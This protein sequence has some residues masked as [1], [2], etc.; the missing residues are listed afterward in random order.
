MVSVED[1]GQGSESIRILGIKWLPTGAA[2][3]SVTSDGKLQKRDSK[4]DRTVPGQGEIQDSQDSNDDQNGL[5]K[6]TSN[7]NDPTKQRL[8]DEESNQ[9]ISEGMEAEEGEFVNMEIA[10]AYKARANGKSLRNLAKN[11]HLYLG[12]Y[13]PG[14]IKFPVWV[15]LQG[16]VG[17]MRLRL[18]LTP[19]PP[20]FS[21]CTL[22]FLGQP[23]VD[24]SCVPLVKKGL[25]IMD[26]P[27]ISN[28]VQSA[29]DAAMA[30]YVAPKSLT[31]DL[32]EMLVGDDFKKD[33]A[34]RGILVVRIRKAFDFKEGDT[35][36]GPIKSGSADAYVTAGWAKFGKPMWS[37]R[38]IESDMNPAWD[39]TGYILVT[40]EELNVRERLRVQ[41]W[42]S[43]R[44]TADDDLGRIEVDLKE[45]M[46]DDRS[47]G[48]MW[49]RQDGFRSLKAGEGMPGKLD[50]SV[51]YF[52][53]TRILEEQ[54]NAASLKDD[55]SLK[56]II[57][58]D[59]KSIADLKR[60]VNAES[61]RKLREMKKDA[62]SELEQ[63]KEQDLKEHEDAIIIATPP[64]KD[65]PSGILSI[66]IH[67]I[68]GLELEKI[69]K[70]QQSKD[71]NASDEEEDGDD[72]PSAYCTIILNHQKVFRTR[73]KPKNAKP[74]FN[75]GCER[76]IRDANSSEIM[77]S[78]RDARVHE[79]DAL[80]GIIVLP[81]KDL[82]R[83]RSQVIDIYPLSGGIGYGKCRI[84]MVFRSVQLQLPR[85]LRG[86][87]Y[88]TVDM[89]QEIKIL[90][91][92]EAV[93]GLRLKVETSL[94]KGKYQAGDDAV[95]KTKR[96]KPVRLAVKKRYSS[97]LV[98]EF[99][100]NSML[101]DSTPAFAVF[102]LRDIPDDEEKTV[103]LAIW[104][105]DLKRA[106]TNVLEEYGEKLGDMEVTLKFWPG[107][108]GYHTSLADKDQNIG[109]V[110]EVLDC[111]ED[112]NDIIDGDADKDFD[113]Q[114]SSSSSSDE[115]DDDEDGLDRR[116]HLFKDKQQSDL[117]NDGKRGAVETL[118]EY[119]NHRKQLHRR[120]RGLMQWKGPRTLQWM[121]NKM[122]RG[123]KKVGSLFNHHERDTEIETE[124]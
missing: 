87:D 88:G 21:L 85:E 119:K 80:L 56:S 19:D 54:V 17:V 124:V 91:G 122:D 58:H 59:T 109:D 20:F 76:F 66:V 4:S 29:V 107:L 1:I 60:K 43:D 64:P 35:G 41:L 26:V 52:S 61:E 55:P 12:F 46:R 45:L 24:M 53:K 67:Q 86:W 16:V 23:K 101:K 69:N 89:K 112:N 47:N 28:F 38:V 37:T 15:E 2:S 110:M 10:F 93:K 84:S 90:S 82:F 39:E 14:N 18:Q 71:E 3:K 102:W 113:E 115:D 100:S 83:R 48:K 108:S 75:A 13:L 50:W 120:N 96:G 6:S 81:L 27:V 62:T 49:D 79:D 95:W 92:Q 9:N 40:P 72:L 103:K 22:T 31:L 117:S 114:S 104:S 32:K 105:G 11:A 121:A 98:F 97:P 36:F 111:A 8:Q 51:G 106:R 5:A 57:G 7:P 70:N 78:V 73:T 25:N 33:T 63:Q 118:E 44:L 99:R 94:G 116:R 68:T 123:G 34:A 65:Y 77:I 30:E 42:D 74:F